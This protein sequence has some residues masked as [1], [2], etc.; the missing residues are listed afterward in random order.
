MTDIK[1]ITIIANHIGTWKYRLRIVS[2]RIGSRGT[3]SKKPATTVYNNKKMVNTF[4][5]ERTL[6][7]LGFIIEQ[8]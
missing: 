5:H 6:K 7:R 3:G 2:F 1:R 8:I 4:H